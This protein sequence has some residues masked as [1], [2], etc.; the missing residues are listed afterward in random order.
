LE[1]GPLVLPVDPYSSLC[2]RMNNVPIEI[3]I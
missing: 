1:I 2:I 3:R